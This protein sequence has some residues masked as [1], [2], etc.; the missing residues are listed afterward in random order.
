VP[1][2]HSLG[3]TRFRSD[4][5]AGRAAGAVPEQEA[6]DGVE[7]LPAQIADGHPDPTP[8]RPAADP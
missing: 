8:A 1:V 3:Y 7:E 2:Q 4:G 6:L 5:A